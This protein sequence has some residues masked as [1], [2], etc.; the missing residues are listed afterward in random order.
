M[1]KVIKT[2]LL[3]YNSLLDKT[4]VNLDNYL[5]DFSEN[6]WS[7]SDS[8]EF[9]RV[10]KRDYYKCQT[11]KI[12]ENNQTILSEFQS[13]ELVFNGIVEKYFPEFNYETE[14]IFLPYFISDHYIDNS[15]S[16]RL[17]FLYCLPSDGIVRLRG[18]DFTINH[19]SNC[20]KIEIID[21]SNLESFNYITDKKIM[22]HKIY[23][24]K[25]FHDN[26]FYYDFFFKGTMQDYFES[27]LEFHFKI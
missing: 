24:I 17:L 7:Y 1:E 25:D 22:N 5:N 14:M 16:T 20:P 13:L 18:K 9:I 2:I 15:N 21:L 23:V 26:F 4:T 10:F 12:E 27:N 3:F 11:Q 19:F 8:I 6:R